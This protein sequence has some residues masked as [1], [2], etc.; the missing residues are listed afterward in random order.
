MNT[1]RTIKALVNTGKQEKMYVRLKN[2]EIGDK[3]MRQ[4]EDEGFTFGDGLKPTERNYSEIMAV[5]DDNTINY[6]NSVGRIAYGSGTTSVANK[7]LI[8]VD[9]EKYIA[10]KED[11]NDYIRTEVI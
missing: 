10:G 9:F 7:K 3:F 5:N 8:R 1:A 2:D 6:V 11:Y 4:A